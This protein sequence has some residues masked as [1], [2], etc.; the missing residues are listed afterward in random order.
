MLT[1]AKIKLF[2]KAYTISLYLP[3]I[4]FP[5]NMLMKNCLKFISVKEP[6]VGDWNPNIIELKFGIIQKMIN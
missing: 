4:F 6:S 1:A 5:E 2:L 3:E